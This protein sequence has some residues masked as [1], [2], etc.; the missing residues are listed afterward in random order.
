M[1]LTTHIVELSLRTQNTR[2]PQTYVLATNILKL[3]EKTSTCLP[4]KHFLTTRSLH[5]A[6]NTQATVSPVII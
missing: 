6:I 2:L 4:Q 3:E 5:W 1:Y